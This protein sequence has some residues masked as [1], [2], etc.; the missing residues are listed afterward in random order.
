M[1]GCLRLG[2]SQEARNALVRAGKVARVAD[3]L[4]EGLFISVDTPHPEACWEWLKFV[5][6]RVEPVRGLPARRSLL[7]SAGLAGQ[8][9]EEAVET[10]RALLDYADLY[11]PATVEASNQLHWLYR[12]VADIW[13]GARPEVALA[14]AQQEAVR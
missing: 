7:D 9:G 10:Y 11:R 2:R 1:Y 8:V 4:Y 12:A 6:G 14:E 3:F 5:S 13:A